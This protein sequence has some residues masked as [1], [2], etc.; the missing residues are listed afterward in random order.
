MLVELMPE[1]AICIYSTLISR[2]SLPRLQV[3]LNR[4][5]H[6]ITHPRSLWESRSKVRLDVLK[7]FPVAIHIA[8][9]HS[10]TPVPG[11][12]SEFQIIGTESVVFDG[13][14]DDLVEELLVAKQVLCDT[15][16]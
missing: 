11:G 16:P 8:K 7:L 15:Q 2:S 14:L 13:R 5:D 3:L 4:L 9:A 6:L 10:L 1:N 12:E